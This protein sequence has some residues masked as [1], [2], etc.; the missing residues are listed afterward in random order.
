[1]RKK[2]IYSSEAYDFESL[3]LTNAFY[4]RYDFNYKFFGQ[5]FLAGESYEIKT[6]RT[7]DHFYVKSGINANLVF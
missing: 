5:V 3:M 2:A 6:P 1:M 4:G 7:E